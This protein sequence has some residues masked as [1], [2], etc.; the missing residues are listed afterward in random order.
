MFQWIATGKETL[1]EQQLSSPC[2]YSLGY[3]THLKIDSRLLTDT[4]KRTSHNQ[5]II[6]HRRYKT[7]AAEKV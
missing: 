6:P 4:Y 7:L 1:K 5:A 2:K 3:Y